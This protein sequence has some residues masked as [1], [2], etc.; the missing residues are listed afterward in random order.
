MLGCHT[1]HANALLTGVRTPTDEH[2]RGDTNGG[3][4]HAHRT[5]SGQASHSNGS[6]GWGF[7]SLRVRHQPVSA[8]GR[9]FGGSGLDGIDGLT[10]GDPVTA[11]QMRALFG[12]SL[13]PLAE[14]R[15]QQSLG[16]GPTARCRLL[17]P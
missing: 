9:G 7:E 11:K 6:E 17:L 10:V 15:Q 8:L 3:P 16:A 14:P 2:G 4:L 13:H 12:C 5:L 1:W